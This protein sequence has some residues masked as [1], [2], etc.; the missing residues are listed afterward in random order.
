M[1]SRWADYVITG[2]QYD[3][4]GE[5]RR[6]AAV[7]VRMDLGGKTGASE[8]WR[9]EQVLNAIRLD[10]E[11]FVTSIMGT[12]GLWS[13]GKHVTLIRVNGIEYVRSDRRLVAQDDL[14]GV[15]EF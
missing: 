6:I 14:G 8:V 15:A 10:H 2:V 11:T 13:R 12:N 5:Q 1:I 9:R 3:H 7:E 4:S